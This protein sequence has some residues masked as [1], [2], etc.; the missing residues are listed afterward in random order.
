M[1]IGFVSM[2]LSGHLNPM[3]ALARKL[4]SRGN[5]V[6]MIGVPDVEPVAQ[7]ANLAFVPFCE[8]EYPFGSTAELWTQVAKLHGLDV[9]KYSLEKFSPGL[10]AAAMEHLPATIAEAGI[11]ALVLDT[12]YFFL[13][14]VPISLGIPYAQAWVVLNLDLSSSTPPCLFGWPHETTPEALARNAEE[15]QWAG[16]CLAPTAERAAVPYAKKTGLEIDW[17][18]PTATN[19][20]LAILSQIPK[21]FDYPGI[22]WPPRFH[23][24]GPF[25]DDQGRQPVP[26]PWEQLNRKPLIYASLGTLVNGLEDVYKTILAAVGSMPDVQLV[27]S[28][29]KNVNFDDLGPVPSNTIIV[30]AAP[31]IE[32][33]RRA[34]LCITHAGLN[35]AMESLAQGVPMV[36]IPIGY[37]QPGVASRLAYHGAGEVVQIEDLSVE[38]LAELV[39]RVRTNPSYREKAQYFQKVI[40]ETR[41][42][43]LAAEVIEEAF[44]KSQIDGSADDYA[45]VLV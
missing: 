44:A 8:K 42:L 38:R 17:N 41:G 13:E 40:A 37:D 16:Q 15:V 24:T 29:G 9:V 4:Q 45:E 26:F 21:E 27:L 28:A 25:Q 14:L 18:D 3:A 35:T 32:L 12:V 2:P 31:Q 34:T 43:D 19:S 30:S 5:D 33:L 22:P 36:A 7:A 39:Q 10:V 6:V 20:K 23:Y 11:E 1:K